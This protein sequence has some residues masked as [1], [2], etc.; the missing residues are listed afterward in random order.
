MSVRTQNSSIAISERH[1]PKPTKHQPFHLT[2]L[3]GRGGY[4]HISRNDTKAGA[5]VH[6]GAMMVRTFPNKADARQWVNAVDEVVE[7]E[8]DDSEGSMSS[9]TRRPTRHSCRVSPSHCHHSH[10]HS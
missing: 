3:L 2:G 7:S 9:Y 1:V 10:S 8:D 5:L 4:Q 6:G